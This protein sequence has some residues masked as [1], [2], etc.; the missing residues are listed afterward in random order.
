MDTFIDQPAHPGTDNIPIAKYAESTARGLMPRGTTPY[1]V[2]DRIDARAD[3]VI[4]TLNTYG[5]TQ[6]PRRA[7]L[8]FTR[9]QNDILM[10]AL[11]GK[12]YAAKIRGATELALFRS[13]GIRSHQVLA[14]KYLNVAAEKANAY[15][16]RISAFRAPRIWTNRVGYVDFD[17]FE[18]EARHDVEIA[19]AAIPAA[20]V[21]P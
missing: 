6:R 16:S 21:T 9:T 7:M 5:S 14:V 2:A 13:T 12:Y 1:Q 4:A 8:E 3:A 18:R 20:R 15:A 10:M 11:L 19:A 17:E